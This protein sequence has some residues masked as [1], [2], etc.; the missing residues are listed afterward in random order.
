MGPVDGVTLMELKKS[1]HVETKTIVMARI[2]T[3]VDTLMEDDE[4]FKDIHK[5]EFMEFLSTLVEKA[6]EKLIS[7]TDEELTRRVKRVMVIEATAGMLQDFTSEEMKDFKEAV[8]RRR[9]FE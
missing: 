3:I 6:P 2:S 7:L 8:K 4:L 1:E 9:L 5:S